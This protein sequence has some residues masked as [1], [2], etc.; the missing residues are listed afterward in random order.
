MTTSNKQ[1]A[2]REPTKSVMEWLER[3]GQNAVRMSQDEEY[4][5]MVA[6]RATNWGKHI[7]A[8]SDQR[9]RLMNSPRLEID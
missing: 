6:S 2:E 1:Q 5:S 3:A 8:R 4:R 9:I 7:Q